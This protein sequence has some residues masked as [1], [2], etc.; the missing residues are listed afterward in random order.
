MVCY[1]WYIV[2]LLD[3]VI[4][5]LGIGFKVSKM[6]LVCMGFVLNREVFCCSL[7]M[8]LLIGQ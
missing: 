6:K 4:V 2:I 5:Y 1:C 3:D 7:P 8:G